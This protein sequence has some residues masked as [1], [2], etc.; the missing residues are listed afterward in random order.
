M[1]TTFIFSQSK[2]F[3][4]RRDRKKSQLKNNIE[5]FLQENVTKFPIRHNNVQ[6]AEDYMHYKNVFGYQLKGTLWFVD[7]DT[8]KKYVS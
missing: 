8:D 7:T 5:V 1:D 6:N 3:S 4:K 2:F